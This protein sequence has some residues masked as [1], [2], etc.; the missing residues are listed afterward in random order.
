LPPDV[1]EAVD[2]ASRQTETDLWLALTT[3][4][5]QNYEK[6]RQ[7]G[8]T[9]DSSAAPEIDTALRSGAVAA[10]QAWCARS[11]PI[12]QQVLDTFKVGKP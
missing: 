5:Q 3:R 1:R 4:L 6:M 7:N 12:C 11:G 2:A 9:I 8:V 10:Q